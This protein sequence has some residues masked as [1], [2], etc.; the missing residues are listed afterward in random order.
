[1]GGRRME[2]TSPAGEGQR[3]HADCKLQTHVETDFAVG[4]APGLRR[5]P[6]ANPTPK[7]P[8]E[9]DRYGQGGTVGFRN[10]VSFP[11]CSYIK[12]H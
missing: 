3:Q 7:P 5:K 12:Q 10:R 9:T 2:G 6:T 8:A 11:L 4:F 1:M